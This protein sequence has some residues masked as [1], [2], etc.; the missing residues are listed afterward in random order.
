MHAGG[1]AAEEETD[2]HRIAQRQKQID[3]GKNTLGYQRYTEEVPRYELQPVSG[4]TSILLLLLV[5]NLKHRRRGQQ[6]QALSQQASYECIPFVFLCYVN[7]VHL[8]SEQTV[9]PLQAFA[10]SFTQ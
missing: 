3:Y 1:P 9:M 4:T 5:L 6:V 10:A 2:A 7:P 8:L